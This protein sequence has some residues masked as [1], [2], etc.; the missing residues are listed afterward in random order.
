M[1]YVAKETLPLTRAGREPAED[2]KRAI[3]RAVELAGLK[4]REV[5]M[6][7][8]PGLDGRIVLGAASPAD[9]PHDL[10]A[11]ELFAVVR[12][13]GSD[14]EVQIR[15]AATDD[16]PLM[17]V[18]TAPHVQRC[19]CWLADLPTT[20]KEVLDKLKVW[21][22]EKVADG[23]VTV[24]RDDGKLVRVAVCQ[25]AKLDAQACEKFVQRCHRAVAFT[26]GRWP[27]TG[28]GTGSAARL[29]GRRRP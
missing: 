9:W 8:S 17:E 10:P 28:R 15:C 23:N 18:Y 2:V 11:I 13:D 6:F 1:R 24:P 14:G 26:R 21:D 16:D 27:S 12:F 4:I 3:R 22:E 29:R 20:L 25:H 7:K 5:R 19:N